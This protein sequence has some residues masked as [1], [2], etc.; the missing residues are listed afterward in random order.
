MPQL[1]HLPTQLMRILGIGCQL[2][3]AFE[4]LHR[5]ARAFELGEQQ[6][7]IADFDGIGRRQRNDPL[8]HGQRL[9]MFLTLDVDRLQVAQHARQNLFLV[10]RDQHAGDDRARHL[11]ALHV[12][13][14]LLQ[15]VQAQ[16][17]AAAIRIE[18]DDAIVYLA[19]YEEM[20]RKRDATQRQPHAA[21]DFD[22]EDRETDRYAH[23][24]LQH[25]V[26]EAVP[27]VVVVLDV[28]RE[29]LL[30]EQES[31][32]REDAFGLTDGLGQSLLQLTSET[33]DLRQISVDVE[34]I[35]DALGDQQRRFGKVDFIFGTIDQIPKA[36]SGGG[37]LA[38]N[39]RAHRS[40]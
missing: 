27:R 24:P 21:A 13:Q 6:A 14:A 16:R 5:R 3:I 9:R 30:V 25:L 19:L 31:V 7:A 22:V 17:Y 39:H 32:Q 11:T 37:G 12:A 18:H 33:F 36:G 26:E 40:S 38:R 2:E 8:H 15:V 34:R 1:D 23:A 10:G 4:V 35:V 28:G 29:A 20:T